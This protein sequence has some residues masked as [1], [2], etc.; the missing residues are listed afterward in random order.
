M[1]TVCDAD[2]FIC[3]FR[4]LAQRLAV[5]PASAILAVALEARCILALAT[6]SAGA[7][8]GVALAIFQ[9][10]ALQVDV[11]WRVRI[12]LRL[13]WCCRSVGGWG[14]TDRR[15]TGREHYQGHETVA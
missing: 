2:G 13:G 9:R 12:T 14:R 15:A 4:S 5:D 1:G 11:R 8:V 3:P 10:K 6:R 7:A